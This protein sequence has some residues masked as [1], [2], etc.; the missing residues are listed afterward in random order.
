MSDDILSKEIDKYNKVW[1]HPRYSYWSH[2]VAEMP[3]IIAWAKSKP[4]RKILILGCGQGYGLHY[5]SMEGF[6]V[7]G[8]DIVNVLAFSK[9]K[10]RVVTA[11]LWDTGFKDLEFD[12][13]IAIDV[14]E[15]IP[16][17][18][19]ADSL[20]EISRI[21][22]FFYVCISCKK[23]RLGKLIDNRLH[24]TVK[25]HWWWLKLL[26]KYSSISKFDGGPDDVRIICVNYSMA[27]KVYESIKK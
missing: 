4:I 24:L 21:C 6:S 1:K 23:D 2:E 11:P 12:A 27:E 22:K 19:V 14:L 7:Y 15:H 26:R 20:A 8:L 25:P 5:L 13:C 9:F 16:E 17:D 3:N 18:K 10:D